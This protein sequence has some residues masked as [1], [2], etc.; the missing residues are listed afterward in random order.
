MVTFSCDGLLPVS[1]R[2]GEPVDAIA[3]SLPVGAIMA[4]D[5][6]ASWRQ[7]SAELEAVFSIARFLGSS[8]HDLAS[9]SQHSL[10]GQT[11]K[12]GAVC[13]KAARTVLS[14]GRFVRSVPT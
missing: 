1:R 9:L 7:K 5:A 12:V 14:G 13:G 4:A 11:S 2:S 8:S 10:R 3:L 6:A